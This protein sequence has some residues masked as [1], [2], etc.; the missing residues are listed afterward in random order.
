VTPPT[1][2]LVADAHVHVHPCFDASR[3]LD[4]AS[5][6][7]DAATG[8]EQFEGALRYLMLTET[9]RDDFFLRVVRGVADLGWWRARRTG[10]AEVLGLESKAGERLMLVAGRQIATR[11]GLEVLALG[12]LERFEDGR[13]FSEALEMSAGAAAITVVPWGFGK[14]WGARGRA[15][16]RAVLGT[17]PD[18]G[19]VFPGDNAARLRWGP[20]PRLLRRAAERGIPVLPG[21]DPF[22]FPGQEDRVGRV[23][24]MVDGRASPERPLAGLRDALAAPERRVRTFGRGEDAL[25]FLRDQ[26]RMQLRKRGS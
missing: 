11:E 23:G 25:P 13:T 21:S 14:W 8:R 12:T 22:P 15:A 18:R 17:D 6:N 7:F 19:E 1:C 24:F 3:L 4:A 26:I 20:M 9:A 10:E 16:E 5:R 2:P